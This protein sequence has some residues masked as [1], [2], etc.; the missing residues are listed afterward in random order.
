MSV[1][2]M[3][4]DD[5]LTELRKPVKM[6]KNVA[7]KSAFIAGVSTLVLTGILGAYLWSRQRDTLD[8]YKDDDTVPVI[9]K[10]EDGRII[11]EEDIENG[12]Y[13]VDMDREEYVTYKDKPSKSEE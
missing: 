12:S 6:N 7:K 5:I 8:Q 4:Y 2:D 13:I 10:D 11:D 9:Y 1:N 3:S